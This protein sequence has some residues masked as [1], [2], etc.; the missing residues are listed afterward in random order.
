MSTSISYKIVG[1]GEAATIAAVL[2]GE[3]TTI[4]A[5]HPGFA[6]IK[7]YLR[8]GGDD[9]ARVRALM[10]IRTHIKNRFR[11]L[12]E[13]VAFDGDR[14]LFDGDPLDTTLSRHL[15][16]LLRENRDVRPVVNFLEK[17]ATNPSKLSKIH[18][19]TWLTDRDFTITPDG[20][21]IGY[22]GV[23]ATHD[24]LSVASGTNPVRVNG[25]VHTG[26]VPNPLGARV[27]IPRSQVDPS[28]DHG[29]STG[30]HVGTWDYA[31]NW[32]AM[33]GGRVLTVAVNPRD[34]V[35]VPR[36]CE[37]AKMQVCGYTVLDV[38]TV[39]LDTAL[40]T[41]DADEFDEF[42]DDLLDRLP[43]EYWHR[44]RDPAPDQHTGTV[45]LT[46]AT[47]FPPGGSI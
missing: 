22:K 12:S 34:V 28:R 46:A 2:D 4:G 19:W 10:D 17:L 7:N 8:N 11:A 24:N 3:L 23:Q 38:T 13:R 29:C 27:E 18:L 14:V 25:T 39:E 43:A 9:P 5:G 21:V 26:H 6:R 30:L 36:D 42:E 16:R 41:D 20:D 32:A 35:A 1:D 47:A 15:V 37:F 31:R 44:D 45:V 40:F 33:H